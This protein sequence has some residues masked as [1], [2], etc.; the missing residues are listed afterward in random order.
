MPLQVITCGDPR[1]LAGARGRVA[2][3]GSRRPHRRWWGVR[4]RLRTKARV[5]YDSGRDRDA[6]VDG[7]CVV[8]DLL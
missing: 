5:G 4:V 6:A 8:M 2:V 1:W 3:Q 7:A